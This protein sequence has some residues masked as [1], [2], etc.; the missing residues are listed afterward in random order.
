MRLGI[1]RGC[2][3]PG[4]AHRNPGR[5]GWTEN[6]VAAP[7]GKAVSAAPERSKRWVCDGVVKSLTKKVPETL[8]FPGHLEGRLRK[9]AGRGSR[10]ILDGNFLCTPCVFPPLSSEAEERPKLGGSVRRRSDP[11]LAFWLRDL[12]ASSRPPDIDAWRSLAIAVQAP[13]PSRKGLHCCA[14]H[15]MFQASVPITPRR[16]HSAVRGSM[17]RR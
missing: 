5:S 7:D 6:D 4:G 8:E 1:R 14:N 11:A 17:P 16:R 10:R 9:P 15:Q 12:I 3:Y 13:T 2:S